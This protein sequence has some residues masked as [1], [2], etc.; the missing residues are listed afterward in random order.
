MAYSYNRTRTAAAGGPDPLTYKA[1]LSEYEQGVKRGKDEE[2]QGNYPVAVSN[3]QVEAQDEMVMA[4]KEAKE[5]L[6]RVIHMG[7]SGNVKINPQRFSAKLSQSLS[8]LLYNAG[9]YEGLKG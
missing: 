9:R 6:D 1:F 7:S 3:L 8:T 2:A 5:L 4:A